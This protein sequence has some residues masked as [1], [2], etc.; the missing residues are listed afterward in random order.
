MKKLLIATAMSA[1]ALTSSFANAADY[2]VDIKG[3]HAFVNFK[4][5]HLGYS[6]LT[7]RFNTFD[8]KFQWDADKPNASNI[9]IT[10]ETASIDSNHAERDKH[11][12]GNDFLDVKKYPTATFKS[13]SYKST[14][15]GKG[16]IT[17]DLTLH[18]V[19]KSITFPVS[20]LGEG[21]DPWGGY[22]T[23]F[24]GTTKLKLS[25]YGISY[26][27]GPASTHVEM[28]LYIEGIRQ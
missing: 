2:Q 18:G 17:G 14:G 3:A 9:E 21:K 19:T 22:R 6:W 7:G 5:Q 13:T 8:G 27:L 12:R 15:K 16:T 24:E 11:L 10:I 23:G 4:I 26:N 28:E 20:Q 1:A 25:D